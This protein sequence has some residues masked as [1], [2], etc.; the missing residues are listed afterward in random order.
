MSIEVHSRIVKA[1]SASVPSCSKL[2]TNS[3][4]N[5]SV[6][7]DMAYLLIGNLSATNLPAQFAGLPDCIRFHT[8]T[9]VF[10]SGNS[11]PDYYRKSFCPP[12]EASGAL[13]DV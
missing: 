9:D 4:L 11:Y 1:S 6:Y 7:S 3:L 8:G 10:D 13:T 12:I 2:M 5:L